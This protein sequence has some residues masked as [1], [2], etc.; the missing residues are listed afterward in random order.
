MGSSSGPS[1]L[2]PLVAFPP[3]VEAFVP[4]LLPFEPSAEE[5]PPP[6]PL[7]PEPL[8]PEPSLLSLPE[9]SPLAESSELHPTSAKPMARQTVLIIMLNTANRSGC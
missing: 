5:L 2:E 3:F 7:L 4:E 6:E 8:P 9:L 1:V